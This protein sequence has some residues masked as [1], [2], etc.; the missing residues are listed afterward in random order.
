MRVRGRSGS[1]WMMLLL[2][3]W[4]LG[5]LSLERKALSSGGTFHLDGQFLTVEMPKPLD[6]ECQINRVIA[7]G[8]NQGLSG[9]K[10]A[11]GTLSAT[12]FNQHD[13]PFSVFWIEL[14]QSLSDDYDFSSYVYVI[15]NQ[16]SNAPEKERLPQKQ[17]AITAGY[18]G[19]M[20]RK[21]Y[22]CLFEFYTSGAEELPPL[23][24]WV[25]YGDKVEMRRSRLL[26]DWNQY[27][28]EWSQYVE[29]WRSRIP[30]LSKDYI[31]NT[32]GIHFSPLDLEKTKHLYIVVHNP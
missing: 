23:V 16:P 4:V 24:A 2:G 15:S 11:L 21:Q 29:E 9:F 20:F 22:G 31:P 8:W 17:L 1:K 30:L 12:D 6:P 27:V 7:R 14:P 19:G 25:G 10:A 26:D 13:H 32:H 18:K 5:T 28:V 3:S